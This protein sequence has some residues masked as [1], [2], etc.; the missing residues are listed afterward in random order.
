MR[1]LNEALVMPG[2]ALQQRVDSLLRE[3]LQPPEEA[4][5]RRIGFSPRA[6][7]ES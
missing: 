3:L 1:S 7:G 6:T 4:P 2:D 5:K